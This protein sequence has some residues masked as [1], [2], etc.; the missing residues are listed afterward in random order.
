M[1][2]GYIN[3]Q[4]VIFMKVNGLMINEKVKIVHMNFMKRMKNI[5]VNLKM[6]LKKVKVNIIL[7]MEISI[8]V[9]SK[10]I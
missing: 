4:M 3:M 9:N 5:L 10:E 1:E 7:L 2:T 8:K 6:E